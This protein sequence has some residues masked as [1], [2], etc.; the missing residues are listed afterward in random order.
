MAMIW[1]YAG[2]EPDR[3]MVDPGYCEG[4]LDLATMPGA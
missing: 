1:V 2:D 3:V 4:R